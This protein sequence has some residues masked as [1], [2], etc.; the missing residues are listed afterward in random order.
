VWWWHWKPFHNRNSK[1][2]IVAKLLGQIY[3]CSRG[4]FK[5]WPRAM[6]WVIRV[7]IPVG[8]GNYTSHH[9]VQT[10]S[11]AHPASYPTGTRGSFPGG[12]AVGREADHSPPSSAE[13]KNAWTYSC[14]PQYA[15]MVWCSVKEE[16]I[17][18]TLPLPYP[19][20]QL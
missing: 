7:W 1:I 13:V 10:S 19:V 20:Q 9:C 8:A 12:K 17:G 14:T 3:S 11:G 15:F 16:S 6:G 18:T 5:R 2:A 4:I